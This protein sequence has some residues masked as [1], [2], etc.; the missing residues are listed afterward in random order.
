MAN[1]RIRR[2][3]FAL[4]LV[5]LAASPARALVMM[6]KNEPVSHVDWPQGCDQVANSPSRHT[7]SDGPLIGEYRFYC[8]GDASKFQAA[9]ELFRAIQAPRLELLIFDGRENSGTNSRTDWEFHI[10][11]T[12]AFVKWSGGP[13]SICNSFSSY[14]RQPVPPPQIRVFLGE[15]SGINWSEVRVPEKVTVL[16]HRVETSQWKDSKGGVVHAI[17][18]DMTTK[19]PIAGAILEAAPSPEQ[20]FRT[21]GSATADDQGVALLTDLPEGNYRLRLRAEGY[22]TRELGYIHNYGRTLE[23]FDQAALC[24]SAILRGR[25]VDGKGKPVE[26][27][28]VG[29]SGLVGPDGMGYLQNP[30]N[31]S[32]KTVTDADG[33]FELTDLPRGQISLRV[34]KAGLYYSSSETYP[35]PSDDA[36]VL[37]VKSGVIRG[38][39]SGLDKLIK[40]S[41]VSVKLAA[42]ASDQVGRWGG[43]VRCEDDGS[44][45]FTG[46]PVDTYIL[47]P[48]V[49]GLPIPGRRDDLSLGDSESPRR[50]T[51]ESGQELEVNLEIN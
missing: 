29:V 46:V 37:M 24:P 42:A 48:Y 20:E 11:D 50:I 28:E 8:A 16:D 4:A 3:L 7:Y 49:V 34:G 33:K 38:K 9:L 31:G 25:V 30:Y 21:V 19:K 1:S 18:S 26:G 2:V 36:M 27:A 13:N 23:T 14:F 45:S 12:K 39:V 44:Y 32:T 6:G 17:A 10:W 47:V 15:G 5:G 51:V 41:M 35:I 40:G 22:A 43:D